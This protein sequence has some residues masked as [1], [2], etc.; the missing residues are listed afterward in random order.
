[1]DTLANTFALRL[2]LAVRR[3]TICAHFSQS[4]ASLEKEKLRTRLAVTTEECTDTEGC[5]DIA[6]GINTGYF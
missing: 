3:V 6:A 4:K 5:T 1:M 2:S